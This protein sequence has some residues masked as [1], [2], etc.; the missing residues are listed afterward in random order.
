MQPAG[1]AL[2]TNNS[3]TENH[4]V[5]AIHADGIGD[6]ASSLSNTENDNA[7]SMQ[8][9]HQYFRSLAQTGTVWNIVDEKELVTSKVGI[10][11]K[12]I[13]FINANVDL[14]FEGNIA[15]I[16]YKEMRIPEPFKSVWWEQMKIHV[17]KKW[18]KRDQIV[19]QQSRNQS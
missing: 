18:M 16:L 12:R 3:T 9:L 19:E 17:R 5:A 13:K 7:R 8:L 6:D 1:S 11:F 2:T 10:I 14:R 4:S 15:K